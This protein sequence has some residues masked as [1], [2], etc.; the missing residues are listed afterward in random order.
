MDPLSRK[1]AFGDE[2]QIAAICALVAEHRNEA[3]QREKILSGELSW[4]EVELR[5][6]GTYLI[7]VLAENEDNAKEQAEGKGVDLLKAD[8]DDVDAWSA[9]PTEAPEPDALSPQQKSLFKQ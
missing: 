2:E 3:E 4:F 1:L 9:V 6:D 5:F 8:I 7:K